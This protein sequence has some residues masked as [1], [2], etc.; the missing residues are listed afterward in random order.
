M[1]EI[2]RE[3]FE[4]DWKEKEIKPIFVPLTESSK[5]VEGING[6]RYNCLS[7][8]KIPIWRINS[9]NLNKRTYPRALAEKIVK[10]NKVTVSLDSHPEDDNYVP[11]IADVIAIGKNPVIEDD[12]LWA[13]AYF[14]DEEVDRKV[15]RMLDLGFQLQ[16][17]SSGLGE[18]DYNNTVIVDTYDLERYFD[19]LIQDSSYEVYTSK[20]NEVVVSKPEKIESIEESKT[21]V[22]KEVIKES[23][24]ENVT[25]KIDKTKKE[26]SMADNKALKLNVKSLMREADKTENLSEKNKLLKEAYNAVKEEADFDDMK[27]DLVNKIKEVDSAIIALAEKGKKVDAVSNKLNESVKSVETLKAER[28]IFVSKIQES[29]EKLTKVSNTAK[30]IASKYKETASKF[31]ENSEKNKKNFVALKEKAIVAE[32]NVKNS[33]SIMKLIKE[34]YNTLEFRNDALTRKIDRLIKENKEKDIEISRLT[35]QSETKR[36]M[37]SFNR[38]DRQEN[39]RPVRE[40]KDNSFNNE[41]KD[42]YKQTAEVARYYE[43]AVR[44]KPFIRQYKTKILE[45]KTVQDAMARVM[46]IEAN[47]IDDNCSRTNLL[48]EKITAINDGKEITHSM[49]TGILGRRKGWD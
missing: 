37:R 45:S 6:D 47:I 31:K 36:P 11:V 7:C 25:I 43:D 15:H 32:K 3:K 42:E 8:Y 18:V 28:E 40:A 9:P 44:N 10:E 33:I 20:E 48:S 27:K 23:F 39:R 30:E 1:R 22:I 12:I 49:S 26:Q 46:K 13:Y 14:V 4:R 24:K 41:Y 16:Q 34:K 5:L 2:L 38:P 17:S 35:R 21:P 19:F 29:A